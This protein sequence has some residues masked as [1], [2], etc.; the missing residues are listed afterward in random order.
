M[1]V[2]RFAW[3]N[4]HTKSN[5][6]GS[7]WSCGG[8][9]KN[10][11]SKICE[12][13]FTLS[14]VTGKWMSQEFASIRWIWRHFLG[15]LALT[16][17]WEQLGTPSLETETKQQK[18][19]EQWEELFKFEFFVVASLSWEQRRDIA[20]SNV[21]TP[22]K[23]L[24]GYKW[25]P[26]TISKVKIFDWVKQ[27]NMLLL[28]ASTKAKDEKSCLRRDQKRR[29]CCSHVAITILQATS[30][31]GWQHW[32]R[33]NALDNLHIRFL[34]AK[35]QPQKGCWPPWPECQTPSQSEGLEAKKSLVLQ[36]SEC[37]PRRMFRS[38]LP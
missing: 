21:Q 25:T 8:Q 2:E 37:D 26:Q 4:K 35:N 34:R 6:W 1:L 27:L 30:S 9:G 23:V 5:K 28:R 3:T 11:L 24:I 10:C 14:D 31:S 19:W 13:S 32:Q 22:G 18:Q 7:S 38:S 16:C 12:E 17:I 15:D 33:K 36:P 20:K 29:A